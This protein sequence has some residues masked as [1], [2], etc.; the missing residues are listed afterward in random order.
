MTTK[1]TAGNW[2]SII[3]VVVGIAL[4]STLS[5]FG[6]KATADT[7]RALMQLTMDYMQADILELKAAKPEL[8]AGRLKLV[9]DEQKKITKNNLIIISQLDEILDNSPN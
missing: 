2:I 8:L 1:M 6:G 4:S 3:S 9:E 5:Y 7:E